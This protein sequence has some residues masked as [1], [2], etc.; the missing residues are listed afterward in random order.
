VVPIIEE[1][2]GILCAHYVKEKKGH[3]KVAKVNEFV[4]QR[5][6]HYMK[7]NKGMKWCM[8]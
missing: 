5:I 6:L 7:D 4:E 3:Y 2:M 8:K 1:Y